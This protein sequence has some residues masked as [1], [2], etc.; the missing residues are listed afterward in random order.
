MKNHSWFLNMVLAA[1][2]TL[3]LL[4]AMVV[5]A[6]APA[7]VLPALN[8]PNLTAISLT[9]LLVEHFFAPG[10]RRC[11]IRIPIFSAVT[12]GL[13]FWAAGL[14]EVGKYALA[15]TGVFTAVT[16]LFSSMVARVA[17][18]P[19]TRAAAAVSAFGLYLASQALTGM[20]L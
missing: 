16:W 19:N 1:L 5:R 13:L 9:A 10:A 6:F 20:L 14:G 8:I 12:F 15:G 17:S 11:Y 7:A 18:G 4:A 2:V 3:A